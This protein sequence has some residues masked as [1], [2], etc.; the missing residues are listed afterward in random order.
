MDERQPRRLD[1]LGVKH[2]RELIVHPHGQLGAMSYRMNR[3][4]VH[5]ALNTQF[6][7]EPANY[8][9]GGHGGDPN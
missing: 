3:R 9:K 8:E 7:Q 1:Q 4:T 2:N 5:A 6:G